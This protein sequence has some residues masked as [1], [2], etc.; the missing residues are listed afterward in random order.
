MDGTF[1][2]GWLESGAVWIED[3]GV[4][5]NFVAFSFFRGGLLGSMVEQGREPEDFFSWEPAG[6]LGVGGTFS[7]GW[8]ES[9]EVEVEVGG[10]QVNF[11]AF[12]VLRGG[13]LGSNDLGITVGVRES[14]RS[15]SWEPAG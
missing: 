1:L 13:W 3:G 9:D 12:S 10:G 7:A 8:S 4:E 6:G 15:V 5:V 2:T 11:G 14:G